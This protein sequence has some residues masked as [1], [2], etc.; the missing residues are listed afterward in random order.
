MIEGE[1][2]FILQIG[3]SNKI[4]RKGGQ[5]SPVL[6]ECASQLSAYFAGKL[7]TFSLPLKIRGTPFQ[8]RVWR[9]L[10]KI[11]YGEVISYAEL[12]QEINA[13]NAWRAVG[14]ANGANPFSIVIP[15][16]RVI[17]S[18]GHLGGYT[19]GL[20]RKKFLLHHELQHKL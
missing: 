13:P 1:G 15:C 19:G 6:R 20:K 12:A 4:G 18:N 17:A 16:H 2:D 8:K 3:H 7:F 11:P 10:G 9:G 5:N 14:N